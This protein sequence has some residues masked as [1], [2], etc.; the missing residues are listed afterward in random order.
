MSLLF[1]IAAGSRQ[2]THSW[3]RVPWDSR[4]YF[5]VRFVTSLFVA[6][7]E[8]QGYGAGIRPLFNMRL[9]QEISIHYHSNFLKRPEREN[10]YLTHT[11]PMLTMIIALSPLPYTFSWLSAGALEEILPV[12]VRTLPPIRCRVQP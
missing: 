10:D 2:R 3:V 7:Y 5:A 1:T 8:S 12:H 11:V 6:Y 4:P 9:G